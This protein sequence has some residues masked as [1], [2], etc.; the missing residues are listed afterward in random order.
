MGPFLTV[1][2]KLSNYSKLPSTGC[3]AEKILNPCKLHVV[4]LSSLKVQLIS[5]R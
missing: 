1:I 5:T 2:Y 3:G 4:N